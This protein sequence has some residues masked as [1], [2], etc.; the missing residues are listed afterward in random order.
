MRRTR[1]RS[2]CHRRRPSARRSVAVAV[3][4]VAAARRRTHRHHRRRRRRCQSTP[5]API[6][7]PHVGVVA[8]TAPFADR[9][10]A[11]SIVIVAVGRRCRTGDRAGP[12]DA[13]RRAADSVNDRHGPRR[14]AASVV[15]T[16]ASTSSTSRS[17]RERARIGVV[18]VRAGQRERIGRPAA[19]TC[20]TCVEKLVAAAAGR[21]SP[22]SIVGQR[23]HRCTGSRRRP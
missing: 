1:S 3:A 23:R 8:R 21:R 10:I 19:C 6:G 9:S 11:P 4:A 16:D 17:R 14:R 7:V 5:G 12:I 15:T 13:Q 22:A 18:R 2:P 20:R